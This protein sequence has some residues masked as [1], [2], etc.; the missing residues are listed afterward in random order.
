M[1]EK[2]DL[3]R[4]VWL[5]DE[6]RGVFIILMV[7]YHLFYDLVYIFEVNIPAFHWR[8]TSYLQLLIAGLFV[9]ISGVA[10]RFSR[11]NLKRGAQCFAFGMVM[12]LAT[13]LFLPSQI[14]L[15]GILHLLGVCMMLFPLMKP[16]LD[17]IPPLA[18]LIVC[19]VLFFLTYNTQSGY[20]GMRGWQMNLPVAWYSTNFLF[21]FGFPNA[22]FWSSDY[23][24]LL[25]WILWYLGGTFAGVYIK[26]GQCPAW[27]YRPHSRLMA[28][29]GRNTFIIY[30]LH[31][32]V[33]YGVLYVIFAAMR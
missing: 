16:V 25:P 10:S 30:L 23:F 7:L 6:V 17:R 3:S 8:F 14:V 31:Q 20:W 26:N 1:F 28:F 29:L 22:E 18:G 5:I 9:F 21:P 13:W 27:F 2:K 19:A 12:T 11:S 15:F 33:V 32:P 24:P 4:R